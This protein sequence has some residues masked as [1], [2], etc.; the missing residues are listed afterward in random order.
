MSISLDHVFIITEPKAA[1]AQRLIELGFVE[2]NPNTH[3]GQG[4]SNRRFFLNGFTIELLYVSD[5]AEAKN[6]PGKRLGII[7]R[8][9]DAEASPYGI[10]VRSSDKERAPIFPNWQ[11][12][13]DYFDGKMSFFV[14]SNSEN[15]KEPLCICM[16]PSLPKSSDIPA[17][18]ANP[19]WHLTNLD[20]QVPV[21]K[22]SDSL[23][24]F[25]IMDQ[26]LIQFGKP[27]GMIMKFNHCASGKKQD[28][29]PELPL[30][31]EW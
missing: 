10:V 4:T 18:Y 26:V 2:G 22:P 24:H 5:Q 21:E 25:A 20:I 19:G 8:Y 9:Q 31:I 28:L 7:S 27:H 17:K 6:G 29:N 14:G 16:P 13:P 3:R 11:Y 12:T 1:A 23:S 15:L 30:V